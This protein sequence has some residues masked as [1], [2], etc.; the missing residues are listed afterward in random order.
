[1]RNPDAP[2]CRC[3]GPRERPTS[4]YCRACNTQN[5]RERRLRL[6]DE[7]PAIQRRY[8]AKLRAAV[9]AAYGGECACCGETTEQ[10][11]SIDH[12]RN[13]GAEHRRT[14]GHGGLRT[15]LYLR[16]QGYPQDAYQLLCHNCNLAKGFYGSCPHYG[17]VAL[18]AKVSTMGR[19]VT[20]A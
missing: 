2:C 4:G 9:L 20:R 11:L 12:I 13:D 19:R 6:P 17:Y 1:M 16:K 5:L 7:S 15:Y 10:F 3:K 8:N 14:V 18:M